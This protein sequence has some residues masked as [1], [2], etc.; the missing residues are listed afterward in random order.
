MSS[1]PETKWR[2]PRNIRG[3]GDAVAI[4]AQ[5]VARII[6]AVAGTS[7]RTCGDCQK[8][9]EAMNRAVPFGPDEPSP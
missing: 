6:D 4:L 7:I 9:R 3:L 8:R 1:Q 2:R 5:P